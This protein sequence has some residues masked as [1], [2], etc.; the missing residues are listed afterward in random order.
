M[1]AENRTSVIA[2]SL[3]QRSMAVPEKSLTW[4]PS[5]SRMLPLEAT[6]YEGPVASLD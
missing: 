2:I 5:N 6:R 3:L 4:T 1:A